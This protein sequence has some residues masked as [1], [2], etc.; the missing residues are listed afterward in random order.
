MT[1]GVP[2]LT[3]EGDLA[4]L[5]RARRVLV[6]GSPGAGKT[7]LS[8]VL[9]RTL[10]LEL[11]RLDDHFWKPGRVRLPTDAWRNVVVQLVA[12]PHWVMD[13]TYEASLDLR[14]PA[15]D[16]IV[17]VRASRW[18]CLWRVVVRRL[19]ARWGRGGEPALGHA[20]T[21]FFVRYVFRFPAVTEPEVF[22]LVARHAN[23]TPLFL[24]DGTHAVDR[25]M[26][27]LMAHRSEATACAGR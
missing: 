8:G 10:G 16:A 13:G 17:Y 4:A 27:R 25:L 6:L 9:S 7:V 24:L 11:L 19:L 15:A 2:T 18:R 22:D 26:R 12:R 21:S 20:L 3:A 14:L 1:T 23:N 5:R